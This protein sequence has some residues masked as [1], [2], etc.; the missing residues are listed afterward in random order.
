MNTKEDEQ[1]VTDEE[2]WQEAANR[3]RIAI[4]AEGDNRSK[5]VEALNFLDGKQWD[6]DLYNKRR[7]ARRPSLTINHT[8]TFRRRVVNNMRQQRPR[9]KVHP[10]G[11]GA[12]VAKAEVI[13]GVIRHIE[14]LS[15]AAV[16]YDTAGASAV[17]IGW[18]YFRLIADYISA[19][20]MDQEI[21]ILPIRNAFTVYFDPDSVMPSGSDAEWCLITEEMKRT[22][23]KL[24]YPKAKNVECLR[25]GTGD[26]QAMWETKTKIRLA[27]YYRIYKKKDTLLQ[28]SNG[29]AV[30]KSN[31]KYLQSDIDAAGAMITGERP[32]M[33]RFVEWYRINGTDIVERRQEGLEESGKGPLPGEYI[34][35]IRCEGNTLDLNGHVR[36]KGMIEDLMD[37]AR[38]S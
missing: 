22:E 25:T 9:I 3:L 32:T 38:R 27:E 17:D 18:G 34:P 24:K 35:V 23:Y 10:V 19:D 13:S 26:N 14:N 30:Y 15:T 4:E 16:A 36:R 8:M 2:I 29:M 12:D 1:G 21:K 31:L 28:L 37:P 11:D 7:I 33:R 5:A 20:S 6:D